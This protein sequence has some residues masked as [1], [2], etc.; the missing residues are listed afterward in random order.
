MR[1]QAGALFLFTINVM[2]GGTGPFIVSSLTDF[3]F[4]NDAALRYSIS[5]V[6][7]GSLSGA[8][9]L[10]TIGL[11]HFRASLARIGSLA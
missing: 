9:L 10:Y 11:K 2:G 8:V 7:L 6:A 4:R 1:G 5:L 3:A